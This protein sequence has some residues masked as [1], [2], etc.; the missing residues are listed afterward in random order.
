MYLIPA[1]ALFWDHYTVLELNSI[2]F[3][4]VAIF[5]IGVLEASG[6]NERMLARL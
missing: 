1:P 4:S 6:W 5:A 3:A 2:H